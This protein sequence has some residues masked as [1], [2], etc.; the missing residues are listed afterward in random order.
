MEEEDEKEAKKAPLL[1]GW[2]ISFASS[3]LGR[4]GGRGGE[5]VDRICLDAFQG[6]RREKS[7]E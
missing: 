2:Y 1:V 7:V 5:A 3:G 4:K 6:K